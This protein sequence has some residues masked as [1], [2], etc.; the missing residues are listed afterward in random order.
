M[1]DVRFELYVVECKLFLGQSLPGMLRG[2]PAKGEPASEGPTEDPRRTHQ[3][4]GISRDAR[5]DV[6]VA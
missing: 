6:E 4:R 5:D 2:K 1:H 3:R